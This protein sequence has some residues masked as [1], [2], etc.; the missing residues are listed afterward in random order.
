MIIFVISKKE[1]SRGVKIKSGHIFDKIIEYVVDNRWS[2]FVFPT[3]NCD[4]KSCKMRNVRR[5][6]QGIEYG[7]YMLGMQAV[8]Y[9]LDKIPPVTLASVI[10]Q[11][12]FM[13]PKKSHLLWIKSTKTFFFSLN[14]RHFC[15][16]DIFKF[17]GTQRTFVYLQ[18]K[19]WNIKTGN[20][21]LFPILN[22]AQICICITTWSHIF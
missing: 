4:V 6:N 2:Q 19:L 11:V 21:S 12:I 9:G 8:N 18:W 20:H 7:I 5:R 1:K 15:I 14:C 22:M 17:P 10:A 13:S 16:L 3:S